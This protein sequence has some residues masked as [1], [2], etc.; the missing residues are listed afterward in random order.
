MDGI[1]KAIKYF[2][3]VIIRG[4]TY[5]N[6]VYLLLA[7]PLG[8]LYFVFLVTGLSLGFGLIVI[9]VGLLILVID[10][11]VWWLFIVMERWQANFMLRAN[12]PPLHQKDLTGLSFME[13][14]KAY[15]VNPVTWK[16]LV[17]LL[18][19]F[20][21]GILAF[22]CLV[23]F[24]TVTAA[25]VLAPFY[26]GF[27]TIDLGF[28]VV[29]TLPKALVMSAFGIPFGFV[30]L[31]ILN[32]LA[33]LFKWLSYW[34]LGNRSAALQPAIAG[35]AVAVPEP[36]PLV[37]AVVSPDLSVVE[38]VEPSPVELAGAQTE[39][40]AAPAETGDNETNSQP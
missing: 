32:G 28:T 24:S 4:Q 6:L 16:G 27:G 18:A 35:T 7:F 40:S 21:L 31:H 26:Y 10:I 39:P 12:V 33:Y 13:T 23:T 1:G 8:L 37:A 34:L 2:F 22:V 38:T 9:W 14:V 5:L 29:D 15:M 19:K 20:P 36:S 30:S 3:G 25:L 11:V 17:Y